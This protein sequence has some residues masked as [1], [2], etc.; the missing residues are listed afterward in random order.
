VNRKLAGLAVTACALTATTAPSGA[1]AANKPATV[2]VKHSRF[3]NIVTDGKGRSLYLFARDKGKKSTCSGA[4]A[5]AW[6]PLIAK[7]SPKAGSG[8]DAKKLHT[9]TRQGG[10]KQVTYNGHPLYRFASDSKPGDVTGQK[11]TNFGGT[12]FVVSP[13]GKAIR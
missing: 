2:T 10:A 4:C 6:P 13:K 12:W 9:S 1:I 7:G 5:A 11:V 8:I 3:G